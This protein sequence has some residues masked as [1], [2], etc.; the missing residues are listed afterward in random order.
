MASR[1]S[2]WLLFAIGTASLLL[3]FKLMKTLTVYSFIE[4][5]FLPVDVNHILMYP[6]V[7][8]T[9]F[10]LRQTIFKNFPFLK[11]VLSTCAV[12]SY[13][14]C[15]MCAIKYEKMMEKLDMDLYMM[16]ICIC[17]AMQVTSIVAIYIPL[18]DMYDFIS[19]YYVSRK[20]NK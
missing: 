20:R 4:L 11:L 17:L 8:A 14:M 19:M 6:F 18:V 10:L 1:F 16:Y 13:I 15:Y 9:C 3:H 5:V 7:V 12:V 2:V